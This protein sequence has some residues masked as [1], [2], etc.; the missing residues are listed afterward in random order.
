M[1]WG[2]DGGEGEI[3]QYAEPLHAKCSLIHSHP[4]VDDSDVRCFNLDQIFTRGEL[5]AAEIL[6]DFG[7]LT[8]IH[9]LQRSHVEQQAVREWK[10]I[11]DQEQNNL[12]QQCTLYFARTQLID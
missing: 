9:R 12:E 7:V 8:E 6:G 5:Q 4:M 10:R 11:L 1:I 2:T 3:T